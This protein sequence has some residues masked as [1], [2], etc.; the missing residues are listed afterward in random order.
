MGKSYHR[1]NEKVYYDGLTAGV[2]DEYHQ[3]KKEKRLD[4]AL[5]TLDIDVS[6]DRYYTF[7]VDN[8]C[9]QTMN[10]F[11]INIEYRWRHD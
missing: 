5:K 4:R 1:E 3:H 9:G 10:G 6:G 11:V 8:Q 7:G 2:D